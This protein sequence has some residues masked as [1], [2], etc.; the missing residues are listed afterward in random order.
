MSTGT[1]PTK[2]QEVLD[3]DKRERGKSGTGKI[4]SRQMEQRSRT[5]EIL[6]NFTA[7]TSAH[8]WRNVSR[9]HRYQCLSVVW[10]VVTVTAFA[11]CVAQVGSLIHQYLSF[12]SEQRVTVQASFVSFPSVTVCNLQPMSPSTASRMLRDPSTKF[13]RWNAM[14]GALL[15]NQEFNDSDS[16]P[17]YE[18]WSDRLRG[19]QGFY[20]NIGS[21][22]RTVGHQQ[23]NF[24]L[25][26]TFGKNGCTPTSFT[27]FSDPTY[28]NCYTYN[29]GNLSA[30]KVMARASGPE[31][32]LS[33]ILY[34]E[35]TNDIGLDVPYYRNY[36]SSAGARVVIHSPDTRP[37]PSVSGFDI[38]SGFTTSVSL[39]VGV[40]RRLGDP[41]GSCVPDPRP[42]IE[43]GRYFESPD[44]CLSACEQRYLM[45]RCRCLSSSHVLPDEVADWMRE[46]TGQPDFCGTYNDSDPLRIFNRSACEAESVHGFFDSVYYRDVGCDCR[47]PCRQ[48]FYVV[49]TSY[50]YWPLDFCQESFYSDYVLGN[51]RFED[52]TAYQNLRKFNVSEMVSRGLIRSNF[53]RVNIY[54]QSLAVTESVEIG[55]Y[56]FF[57]LFSSIG[58]AF[59][60][61]VGMSLLTWMEVGELLIQLLLIAVKRLRRNISSVR[62]AMIV[63]IRDR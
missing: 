33:L 35:N 56:T 14:S 42:T 54:P 51:E 57:N 8:G 1:G 5:R 24:I 55:T 28:F 21:E 41:Y 45:E 25:S 38:P 36:G 58:G 43:R 32:G 29:G 60:L 30:E 34:L 62:P 26:C 17:G 47:Q 18:R 9:Q 50:S 46:G 7:T 23:H 48:L 39:K 52:L 15:R 12:P 49:E 10:L 22:S 3:N 63:V 27:Y 16:S 53:A 13:A 61:W 31:S 37:D 4:G 40:S 44:S 11:L 20:D 6:Q 19:P 2:H 59:G